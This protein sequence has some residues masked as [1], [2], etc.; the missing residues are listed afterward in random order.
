LRSFLHAN[1]RG[2][3]YLAINKAT[4]ATETATVEAAEATTATAAATTATAAQTGNDIAIN[5]AGK[6]AKKKGQIT[7]RNSKDGKEYHVQGRATDAEIEQRVSFFAECLIKGYS[8]WEIVQIASKKW[9]V[10]SR[11]ADV[12]IAKAKADIS[13]RLDKNLDYHLTTAL[14]RIETIYRKAMGDDNHGIALAAVKEL[15]EINGFKQRHTAP[16]ATEGVKIVDD[17]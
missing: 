4:A 16:Q 12:Y 14:T 6:P 9:D 11:T 1:Q 3:D 2:G 5:P 7:N 8:R 17:L 15:A 13:S 10:V